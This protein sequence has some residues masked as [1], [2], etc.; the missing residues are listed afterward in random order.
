MAEPNPYPLQP[1]SPTQY[2][3]K[4]PSATTDEVQRYRDLLGYQT[5]SEDVGLFYQLN[6]V[7]GARTEAGVTPGTNDGYNGPLE[8][9]SVYA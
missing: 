6:Q 5:A 3:G 2:T 8:A 7:A 4:S 1:S 9:N